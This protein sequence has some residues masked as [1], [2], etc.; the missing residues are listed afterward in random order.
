MIMI[1]SCIKLQMSKRYSSKYILLFTLVFVF[2]TMYNLYN[3]VSDESWMMYW[4]YQ[5]YINVVYSFIIIIWFTAGGFIDIKK[6]F[7][8]LASDKRDHR[9][10]GWVEN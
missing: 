6:M 5:V 4:K 1:A 9:D 8:S 7:I 3:N 2:G 10:S